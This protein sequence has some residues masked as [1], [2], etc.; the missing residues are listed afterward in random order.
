MRRD[1]PWHP[2]VRITC[3]VALVIM[4]GACD[5]PDSQSMNGDAEEDVVDDGDTQPKAPPLLI[6]VK[7]G[8]R[9]AVDDSVYADSGVFKGR[10]ANLS[11]GRARVNVGKPGNDQNVWPVSMRATRNDSLVLVH[12]D[13]STAGDSTILVYGSYGSAT[14][15]MDQASTGM[16][17]AALL[18]IARTEAP[19]VDLKAW[20][21]VWCGKEVLACGI[22]PKCR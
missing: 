20:E 5:Q 17:K 16:T 1:V 4:I 12:V 22:D 18:S 7:N 8:R 6:T 19:K 9:V 3:A 13:A 10:R 2:V 21:C 11:N 15:G 14:A